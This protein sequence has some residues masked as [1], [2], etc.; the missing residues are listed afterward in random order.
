[1]AVDDGIKGL[2]V[3]GLIGALLGILYA[4]KSGKETREDLS[5]SADEMFTKAKEQY[6]AACV[7][8]QKI[9][10]READC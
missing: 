2:V 7:K 3:G 1:M 9:T 4:P 5:K 8:Y 6:E 10:G